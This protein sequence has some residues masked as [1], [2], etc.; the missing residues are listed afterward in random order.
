MFARTKIGALASGEKM[1]THMM[2]QGQQ[3][4]KEYKRPRRTTILPGEKM[5]K[6]SQQLQAVLQ[7]REVAIQTVP[8]LDPH[9]WTGN[10]RVIHFG[11][12]AQRDPFYYYYPKGW[13][14][15]Y[16]ACFGFF[17]YRTK[18]SRGSSPIVCLISFGTFFTLGG[19]LMTYL[20]YTEAS[21]MFSQ[22]ENWTPLLLGGPIM[23]ALGLLFMLI[24]SV[25]YLSTLQLCNEHLRH[26]Q[27]HHVESRKVFVAESKE[28]AYPK[29]VTENTP[30]VPAPP[31][32]PVLMN[33][34][35]EMTMYRPTS[36]MKLFP[37][38]IPGATSTLSVARSQQSS[39]Q[40]Q[41]PMAA[42][43]Q[44]GASAYNTLSTTYSRLI[45]RMDSVGSYDYEAWPEYH[46]AAASPNKAAAFA[47]RKYTS[48]GNSQRRN[49]RY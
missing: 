36:E 23:L 47:T 25:W 34:H 17:P 40:L 3:S 45:N 2:F 29:N 15:L 18:K 8:Q 26:T 21:K 16:P 31:P 35:T 4:E 13:D 30:F 38:M 46:G 20:S 39:Y 6:A 12:M 22:V 33:T 19:L 42:Q 1:R 7:G 14:I 48:S 44:G 28:P 43:Q 41:P 37:P 5:L 11:P 24:G 9:Q 10:Q 49:R 27:P 32:V